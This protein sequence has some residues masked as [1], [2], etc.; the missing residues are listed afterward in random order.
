MSEKLWVE[1][2]TDKKTSI[3]KVSIKGCKDV[4]DFIE[5]IKS[6]TQFSSIKDPEI[7]LN[8]PSGAAISV[9]DP[10]SSLVPGNSFTNPL[11]V[12]VSPLP[13]V[14]IKPASY[15]ELTRFWNLLR[16]TSKTDEFLNFHHRPKFFL[17]V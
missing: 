5:K 16:D 3:S 10:I 17:N 9:G 8:G 13:L 7:T 14:T 2:K 1:Y 12:Q 15:V 11:R 6:H 4:D